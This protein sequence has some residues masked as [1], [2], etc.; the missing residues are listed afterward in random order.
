MGTGREGI[1]S[2]NN[3]RLYIYI[4]ISEPGNYGNIR[5]NADLPDLKHRSLT[6]G[7]SLVL[8]MKHSFYGFLIDFS[9]DRDFILVGW[10]RISLNFMDF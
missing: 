10:K 5:V 6:T 8:Y 3:I 4:Y 1:L 2:H 7:C 9:M